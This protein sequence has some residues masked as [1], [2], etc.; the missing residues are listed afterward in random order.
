[1]QPRPIRLT[2]GLADTRRRGNRNNEV[3][4]RSHLAS[5]RVALSCLIIGQRVI[6]V[7][8]A[9][10]FTGLD[11][12]FAGA[13]NTVGAVERHVDALAIGGVGD[14][15]DFVRIDETGDPVFEVKRNPMSHAFPE[16]AS[17]RQMW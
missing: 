10:I 15:F 5:Q 14:A 9:V 8:A 12:A 16:P 7:I 2:P 3:R 6:E 11:A 17:D 4:L 1:M 13:A